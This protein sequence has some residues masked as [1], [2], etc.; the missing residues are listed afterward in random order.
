MRSISLKSGEI[1]NLMTNTFDRFSSVIV[2][3]GSLIASSMAMKEYTSY[4]FTEN[5]SVKIEAQEKS[6]FI[7][8]E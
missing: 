4:L 3:N 8:V 5:G 7:L 6:T 2:I 1:F